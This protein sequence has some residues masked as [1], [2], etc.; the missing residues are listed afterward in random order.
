MELEG[1]STSLIDVQN[2]VAGVLWIPVGLAEGEIK[3]F[4]SLITDGGAR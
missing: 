2:V 4:V 3:K 1:I